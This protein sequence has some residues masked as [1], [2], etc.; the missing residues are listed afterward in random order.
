MILLFDDQF[1]VFIEN[2]NYICK[3]AEHQLWLWSF[4]INTSVVLN[5]ETR[6]WKHAFRESLSSFHIIQE[7]SNQ[8]WHQDDDIEMIHDLLMFIMRQSLLLQSV[9]S[10]HWHSILYTLNMTFYKDALKES[11][12]W[13]VNQKQSL[14][15]K[16]FWT[17]LLLMSSKTL[18]LCMKSVWSC[19][20]Y[21]ANWRDLHMIER[22][23]QTCSKTAEHAS[24]WEF[25]QTIFKLHWTN[26]NVS[27]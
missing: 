8:F 20:K 15:V 13:S 22:E 24:W 23:R 7:L 11:L 21:S 18:I 14:S 1:D 12:L 27:W 19:F 5:N 17:L 10:S 26:F 9:I 2:I 4:L 16:N 6:H 25:S 3:Q